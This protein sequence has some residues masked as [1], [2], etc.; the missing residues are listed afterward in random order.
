MLNSMARIH[1]PQGKC[2]LTSV[3]PPP[4]PTQSKSE[5]NVVFTHYDF[6]EKNK[7][8]TLVMTHLVPRVSKIKTVFDAR[9]RTDQ[10]KALLFTSEIFCV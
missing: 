3:D 8:K 10:Q 9:K 2:A 7:N 6:G 1:P 5:L 4:P